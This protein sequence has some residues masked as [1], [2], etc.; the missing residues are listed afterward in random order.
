MHCTSGGGKYSVKNKTDTEVGEYPAWSRNNRG[1]KETGTNL[2][3][4]RKKE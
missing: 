1:V 3:E 4:K 2:T